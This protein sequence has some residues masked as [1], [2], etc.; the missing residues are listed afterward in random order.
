MTIVSQILDPNSSENNN[1]L[2]YKGTIDCSSNPNYPAA[3]AGYVYIVSVAGKIGGSSGTSVSIGASL[4]CTVDSSASG[5]QATVGSNWNI[6]QSSSGFVTG[7]GSSVN[8]NITLFDGVTGKTI[9]D[10]GKVITTDGTL[11]S[12]SDSNVPTEKAVKTYADTKILG[13]G[14]QGFDNLL[15]NGDFEYWYGGTSVAPDGWNLA[16]SGVTIAREST[17]VKLGTYSAK[18]TRTVDDCSLYIYQIQTEKGLA[19][20]KGRTFTLGCWVYATVANRARIS[21]SGDSETTSAYHSGNSTW[22]WL[23]VTATIG[24]STTNVYAVLKILN[25]NTSVYFD[26]AILVEGTKPITYSE[27]N[28]DFLYKPIIVDRGFHSVSSNCTDTGD[29]SYSQGNFAYAQTSAGV[30]GFDLPI[31]LKLH[32]KSVT[33]DSCIVYYNTQNTGSYINISRIGQAYL[34]GG[35]LYIL[36]NHTDDL[37]N[38]STG[39]S[40]HN[41]IDSPI[42]LSDSYGGV[43]V[44]FII[45]ETS[46]QYVR[47]YNVR[48]SYHADPK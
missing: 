39:D 21:I 13:D 16:G 15:V 28:L 11:A 41:I 29:N 1:N 42:V 19:Y 5:D 35:G 38:G 45:S 27:H 47:I 36:L 6:Q 17:I 10:S 32:N 22:E 43:R 23:T 20:W 14:T 31:P 7:P 3:N 4:L 12:N 2:I 37:G 48:V 30:I 24:N 34:T 33:L 26:G 25:G 46:A 8:N 40:N 9:K 18:L 44:Y